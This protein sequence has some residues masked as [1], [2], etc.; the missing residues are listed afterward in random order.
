MHSSLAILDPVSP[1][2]SG[3]KS[4]NAAKEG[5]NDP[6]RMTHYDMNGRDP[7]S[8]ECW[9]SSLSQKGKAPACIGNKEKEEQA[10]FYSIR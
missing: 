5:E 9:L 2:W 3:T 6:E 4:S 7:V 10:L 8:L 1:S